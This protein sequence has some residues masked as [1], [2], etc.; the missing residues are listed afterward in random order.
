M[1]LRPVIDEPMHA[2]DCCIGEY[3]AAEVCL[4]SYHLPERLYHSAVGQLWLLVTRLDAVDKGQDYP[5][6]LSICTRAVNESVTWR[7]QRPAVVV[8][9][10]SWLV[11]HVEAPC[12]FPRAL[13][14]SDMCNMCGTGAV[15]AL[16]V[17]PYMFCCRLRSDTSVLKCFVTHHAGHKMRISQFF[18]LQQRSTTASAVLWLRALCHDSLSL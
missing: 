2:G 14:G 12:N 10:T 3:M 6:E 7:L 16:L 15:F 5:A 9:S 8:S 18:C 1:K 11:L 4:L 13:A 17:Q